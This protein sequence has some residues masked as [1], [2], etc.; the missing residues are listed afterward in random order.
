MAD[1]CRC[2]WYN[3]NAATAVARGSACLK[4]SLDLIESATIQK[5]E[6]DIHLIG[7]HLNWGKRTRLYIQLTMSNSS[8]KLP[9]DKYIG[10]V[11]HPDGELRFVVL[12]TDIS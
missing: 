9:L 6:G 7:F 1:G 11:E 2:R 4:K 3:L 10:I 12:D 5:P 8:E